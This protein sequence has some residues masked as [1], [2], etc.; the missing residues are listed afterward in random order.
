MQ[1][2]GAVMLQSTALLQLVVEQQGMR[3]QNRTASQGT[4]ISGGMEASAG[5]AVVVVVVVVLVSDGGTVHDA[6]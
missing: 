6:V 3:C 5:Y 4:L 2:G 1:P